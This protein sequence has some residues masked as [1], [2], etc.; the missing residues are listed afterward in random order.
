MNK[1]RILL[2]GLLP[3]E[4]EAIK[5]SLDMEYLVIAYDMLPKL[6]LVENTLWVESTTIPDKFLKVDK[7]IFHG[8]FKDDYDLITLLALW[9]GPCLPNAKAMMDLRQ[10][11]PGLVRTL[12]ISKFNSLKRGMAIG[13]E[14][15]NS[16][17]EVVAKWGVW[18]CGEDKHKFNGEWSTPETCVIEEFVNGNA[19][20]IMLIGDQ[21]WQI[22][23][24]GD[25]WLKS[26]HH[27]DAEKMPIDPELLQDS[28]NIAKHFNLEI[29]GIDYM[30]DENGEKYIL[31]VNHIPNVTVFP[32]MNTVFI[33]YAVKWIEEA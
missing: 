23:L 26:I 21:A 29:A 30:I 32:F 4:I 3:K 2:I 7:V 5:T 17:S 8:I 19:V 25:S 10:R 1:K 28:K 15:W 33:D 24:H 12:A 22:Q 13:Q 20:R 16:S 18:H 31:E 9:N 14:Q 6:K 11:I 27:P